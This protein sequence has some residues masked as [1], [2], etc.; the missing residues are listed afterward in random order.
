MIIGLTGGIGSGKST[1]ARV[2][3][4]SSTIRNL[5]HVDADIIA[6]QVMDRH[7]KRIKSFDWHHRWVKHGVIDR[8]ALFLEMLDDRMLKDVV[9]RTIHG[10]VMLATE[11][12]V[13]KMKVGANV[14]LDVPLL[15]E[16]KMDA[17]C[18]CTIAVS[19][20]ED[21]QIRRVM[22]RSGYGEEMV[23]K[24]IAYQ[25][26]DAERTEKADYVIENNGDLFEFEV[27]IKNVLS[28]IKTEYIDVR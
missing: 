28:Q 4:G 6:R 12:K 19:I 7:E 3:L 11:H 23:R 9:E 5:E 1:A 22:E 16:S 2:I 24:I 20:R 18:T 27:A 26:S 10:G 21:L 25:M 15:F 17:L 8:K 14:L 13:L